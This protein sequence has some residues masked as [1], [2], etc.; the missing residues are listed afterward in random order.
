M[1]LCVRVKEWERE[2]YGSVTPGRS[3]IEHSRARAC[4]SFAHRAP[5][6]WCEWNRKRSTAKQ[7]RDTQ[8]YFSTVASAC[9]QNN[10][11]M[12]LLLIYF[13]ILLK[14]LTFALWFDTERC[15]P[16]HITYFHSDLW[17]GIGP[18]CNEI[19]L[20]KKERMG[21]RIFISVSPVFLCLA[22]V[23]RS[24]LC[25]GAHAMEMTKTLRILWFISEGE[26]KT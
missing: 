12:K 26:K 4:F 14:R 19:Q 9:I 15:C 18:E 20:G 24:C 11:E 16:S 22:A 7:K 10:S 6:I 5:D 25:L 21:L 1:R 13:Y 23:V 3:N 8:I 2:K 17:M